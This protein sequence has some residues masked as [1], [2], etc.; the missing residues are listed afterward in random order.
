MKSHVSG[1]CLNVE[2][3]FKIVGKDVEFGIPELDC[4]R[5]YVE[6]DR[7]VMK[8]CKEAGLAIYKK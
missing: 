7:K 3:I 4:G 2:E 5:I 8:R 6:R 1:A